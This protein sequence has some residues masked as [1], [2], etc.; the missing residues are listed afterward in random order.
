MDTL[1][2]EILA[3]IDAMKKST[4][5]FANNPAKFKGE[6]IKQVFAKFTPDRHNN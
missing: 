6:I 5:A 2:K 1:R 3:I 4:P